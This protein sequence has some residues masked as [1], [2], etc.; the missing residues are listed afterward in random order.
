MKRLV[1]LLVAMSFAAAAHADV[2]I[3]TNQASTGLMVG[4]YADGIGGI[5]SYSIPI[6]A[7]GLR[8]SGLGLMID[9][10]LGGGIGDDFVMAGDLGLNLMFFLN[11]ATSIYAGLGLGTQLLPGSDFGPSGEIGINFR[12][13]SARLFVEAGQHAGRNNYLGIGMRF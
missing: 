10:E 11:N 12:L 9:A 2:N 13:D 5:F 7:D 4:S 3:R 6:Q 1:I 8:R